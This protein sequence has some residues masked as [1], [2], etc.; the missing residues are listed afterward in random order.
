VHEYNPIE[1]GDKFLREDSQI[2][3][4]N[5]GAHNDISISET[6]LEQSFLENSRKAESVFGQQRRSL[7]VLDLLGHCNRIDLPNSIAMSHEHTL[8]CPSEAH[9]IPNHRSAFPISL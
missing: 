8:G 2:S 3:S 6:R 5:D 9:S 1:L 7:L 4:A